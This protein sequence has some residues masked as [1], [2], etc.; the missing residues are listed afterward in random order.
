MEKNSPE[1][2]RF[3]IGTPS[4]TNWVNPDCQRLSTIFHIAHIPVAIDIIRDGYLEPRLICDKS[5]LNQRRI[6]VTWLSPN[7]W[8][9]GS[10]YGNVQFSF[11]WKKL[12]EGDGKR[13][14]WVESIAYGVPACRILV[15][16]QDHSSD[17]DLV[18]FDPTVGDGPWWWE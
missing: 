3:K 2:Q 4:K 14:Y 11:E 10:R 7:S 8:N 17:P 15:T 9:D 12:V 13:F 6:T 18:E 1:W 5:K 16:K